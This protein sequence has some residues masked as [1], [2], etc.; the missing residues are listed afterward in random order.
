MCI[1]TIIVNPLPKNI[2]SPLIFR[3]MEG[4]EGGGQR[5]TLFGIQPATQEYALD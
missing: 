4:K 3:E 5:E 1:I 2:F